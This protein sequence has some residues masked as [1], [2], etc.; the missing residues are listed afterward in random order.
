MRISPCARTALVACLGVLAAVCVS[1]PAA[2]STAWLQAT[3]YA[4]PKE[5]T[6]QGSGYFSIVTGRDGRLYIGTAKYGV[7]SYLVEFDPKAETMRVVVDTHQAIGTNA[8]GF[9]AQSKI[10][11]RNNVGASGR[12]YFGTKQGYPEK[13]EKRT[14]YPGGYPMVYD[15]ATGKTQVYPIP[16]PH[17]GVIS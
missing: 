11:T 17:Q 7:G 4:I 16:V 12:I 15:P 6:N 3:A 9:A 8:R 14:D 5:T 13:G 1:L 2:P 10:H